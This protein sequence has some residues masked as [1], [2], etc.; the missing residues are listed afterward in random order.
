MADRT[1]CPVFHRLWPNPG[2]WREV[3][4]YIWVELSGER[5]GEWAGSIW[6][7]EKW[8]GIWEWRVI[9]WQGKYEGGEDDLTEQ[10]CKA[11]SGQGRVGLRKR[12]WRDK[13]NK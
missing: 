5:A 9:S 1:G 11:G 7:V 6:I 4:L 3:G 8:V 13:L 12:S 2:G 10:G